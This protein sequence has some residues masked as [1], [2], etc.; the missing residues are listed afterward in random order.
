[1]LKS[2]K[3][4]FTGNTFFEHI[5]LSTSVER[6]NEPQTTYLC[7]VRAGAEILLTGMLI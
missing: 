5:I 7:A 2:Q 3:M 1:M 4:N 6:A